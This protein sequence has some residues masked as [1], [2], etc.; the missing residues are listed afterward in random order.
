MLSSLRLTVL[1]AGVALLTA[2]ALRAQPVTIDFNEYACSD[3]R[4]CD[5]PYQAT[6]GNPLTSRGYEFYAYS[7]SANDIAGSQALGTW[8]NNPA[9]LGYANRPTNI[10][11]ATTLF[12]VGTTDRIEMYS[13]SPYSFRVSSMDVA[14]LFRRSSI[15]TLGYPTSVTMYF[16]YY[17]TLDAYLNG[18]PDGDFSALITAGPL[19]GTD[20]APVLQT[21][22]FASGLVGSTPIQWRTGSR[23]DLTDAAGIYGLQWFQGDLTSYTRLSTF[24]L[25]QGS[26]RSYQF[27][28]I[29]TELVTP[30]PGTFALAAVGIG[31][32]V[33]VGLRRRRP[34][35]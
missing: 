24:T 7:T 16:Q 21:L 3:P 11:T 28:N 29:T 19:V 26:G 35:A 10:G 13:S 6:I 1:A 20:R 27:T 30:E 8:S 32:V 25:T 33:G 15:P 31:A 22:N 34:D 5:P 9:N 14:Y 2:P 23:T 4:D 18:V 12:G 17:K